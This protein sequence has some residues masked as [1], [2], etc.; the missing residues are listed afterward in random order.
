MWRVQLRVVVAAGLLVAVAGACAAEVEPLD[1]SLGAAFI[2]REERNTYGVTVADGVTTARATDTNTGPGNDRLAFWRLADPDLVDAET[3]AT[4][5]GDGPLGR[6]PGAALRLQASQTGIRT[7]TVTKNVFGFY[8][9]V[10]VHLMDSAADPQ[11]VL[12]RQ[13]VLTGLLEDGGEGG[14]A[15]FPWRL[16]ARVVG[17]SV[18]FKIWPTKLTEPDWGD[19]AFG[20]HYDLDVGMPASGRFG[21]Y[22]GHLNA[23]ELVGFVDM[24]VVDLAAPP[25]AAAESVVGGEQPGEVLVEEEQHHEEERGADAVGDPLVQRGEASQ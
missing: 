1:P 19:P 10:N 7:L 6:Q 5:V 18:D 2:T 8:H 11:V 23:G 16:C 4:W 3:C 22:A 17:S 15:P 25:P 9:A 21:W 14:V 20:G 13:F 12:L 24:T